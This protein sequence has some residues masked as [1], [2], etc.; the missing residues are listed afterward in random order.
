LSI[1]YVTALNTA[2]IVAVKQVQIGVFLLTAGQLVFP[3]LYI[4]SDIFSEVYGY[5]ASRWVAWAAFGMNIVMVMIFNLTIL[6]PH[7]LWWENNGAFALILGSVPRI[8]AASLVAFQAGDW[9][10]DI[11][12]QTMKGK[13]GDRLFWLRAIVSSI[14]GEII[15]SGL[16]FVIALIRTMPISALP[17]FVLSGVTVKCCYE[18]VVLP[19]TSLLIVV[20]KKHEL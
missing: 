6:L 15:D 17:I 7:P 8:L 16:F 18:L 12:F 11:I 4:L 20:I 19:L 14:L 3:V 9:L 5:K 10:N 2:N 13:H 1:I